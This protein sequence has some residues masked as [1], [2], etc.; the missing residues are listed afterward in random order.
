MTSTPGKPK[1]FRLD[2]RLVADCLPLGR[3]DFSLL[4][5]MNE[6]RVPWFILV[7][8]Q[9]ATEL[10]DLPTDHQQRLLSEMNVLSRFVRSHFPVEKLNVAALGNVVPQLHVH[11][12][13]RHSR[14]FCWPQPV[15]GQTERTP[16]SPAAHA[17]IQRQLGAY[18]PGRL[19]WIA[20]NTHD[21][22][23]RS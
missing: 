14:D 19:P 13:G 16:Y 4:L 3:L 22:W 21:E 9:Q 6:A 2:P 8:Q 7:P 17:E 10:C 5:L 1:N 12:I 18:L 11:V 15:W 20:A 23:C